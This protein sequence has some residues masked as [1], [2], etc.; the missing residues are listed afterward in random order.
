MALLQMQNILYEESE[1]KGRVREPRWYAVEF[2]SSDFILAALILVE[3]EETKQCK[4]A[5]R[6]STDAVRQKYSILGLLRRTRNIWKDVQEYSAEARK[7]F[8][9]LTTILEARDTL[10]SEEIRTDSFASDNKLAMDN[11]P[12]LRPWSGHTS[13]SQDIP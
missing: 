4:T 13:A 5:G 9:V 3:R 8:R 11:M 10:P 2:L 6:A 7:V 1:A 12:T